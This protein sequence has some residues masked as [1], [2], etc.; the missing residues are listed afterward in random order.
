MKAP[1]LRVLSRSDLA[2]VSFPPAEVVAVVRE[3]YLAYARADSANP[4]KI[5]LPLPENRSVAYS[6]LG[7]D[8]ARKAVGFQTHY[9][10]QPSPERQHRYTTLTLYDD[11][12][13][14]PIA[15]MDCLRATSLR[16]SAATAL[17]AEASAPPGARTV[18]LTGTGDLGRHTLPHLV[19]TVPTLE[20]FLLYG[21]HQ[22]GLQA[23]RDLFRAH[24]PDDE[25][26]VVEDPAAAAREA[27][28]VIVASGP[29]TD[30]RAG[31]DWLKPGS[32][33]IDVGTGVLP[34]AYHE[35]DHTITTSA[36]Q[37]AITGKHLENSDGELPPADAE[38]PHILAGS[39]VGR[40]NDRDRVFAYNSGMVV[41]DIAVGH[42]LAVKAI[43][44]GRGHEAQP[45]S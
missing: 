39:A 34:S 10:K 42:T 33:L 11:E 21:R 27:D 6:M 4:A 28:I 17:L 14:E 44:A 15:L 31:A 32:T 5:A 29:Q 12:H 36:S 19:H 35:S 38:L 9:T 22:E 1:T 26:E 41:T 7:F 43:A 3:A 16:T 24:R 18:L 40:K 2:D 8:G 13:G 37:L 23:V 30:V 25:V 45:W 20:R